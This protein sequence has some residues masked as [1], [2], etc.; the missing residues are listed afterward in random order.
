VIDDDRDPF[1]T[2]RE[3]WN[4]GDLHYATPRHDLFA[5]LGLPPDAE[6]KRTV[7]RGT[8]V[9][10]K[11]S[12]SQLSRTRGGADTVRGA[13]KAALAATGQAWAESPALVLRRGPYVIAAGLSNAGAAEPP[14]LT[15][16]F[17]PLF[18]ASQPVVTE[19][20]VGRGVRGLLVDLDRYP[21]DHAGVVAAACRVRN[22][23]VSADSVTFDADGQSDTDAVVSVLLPA[24]P[25]S[26][27]VDG[28]RLDGDG[29]AYRDGVLRLRFPNSPAA[30]PV[31]IAR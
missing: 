30:I 13:V 12:P 27:S 23:R 20:T 24:A 1:N 28:K 31:V 21:K 19:F 25:K 10:E 15:G 29:A 8:V 22:E 3:W 5:R 7:G 11:K 4:T 2:V 16:R 14:K 26:V 6:G 9:Y 18:D 17:I